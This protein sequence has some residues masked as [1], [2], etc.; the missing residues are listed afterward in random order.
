MRVRKNVQLSSSLYVYRTTGTAL[1]SNGN[2]IYQTDIYSSS[3]FIK[4]DTETM[5]G[6]IILFLSGSHF[7]LIERRIN[8]KTKK[9]VDFEH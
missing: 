3:Q 7:Y 4:L 5:F 6:R 1:D 9:T 2:L 8:P